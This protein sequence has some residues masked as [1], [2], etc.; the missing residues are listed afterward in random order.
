MPDQLEK[1]RLDFVVVWNEKAMWRLDPKKHMFERYS[2]PLYVGIKY[3]R[4]LKFK[5]AKISNQPNNYISIV[6]GKEKGAAPRR[7]APR[8]VQSWK[9]QFSQV[10]RL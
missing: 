9:K 5:E 2:K 7:L 3:D 8:R 6:D 10:Y 4:I 1:L